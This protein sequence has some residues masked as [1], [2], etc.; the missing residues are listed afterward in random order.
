[1]ELKNKI[2][3]LL[4]L[5]GFSECVYAWGRKGHQIV[6]EIAQQNLTKTTHQRINQILN[7]KTLVEV[8]TWA[9]QMRSM[10]NEFWKYHAYKWHY[11]NFK[12]LPTADI[13]YLHTPKHR[14]DVSNL[15]EAIHHCIFI[16]RSTKATIKQQRF[17]LK[18]LVH[19]VADSHQPLHVG[20]AKDKGG[21]LINV[22]FFN[23]KTNLHRVW[24]TLM[25]NHQKRSYKAFTQHILNTNNISIEQYQHNDPIK[26]VK[27]SHQLTME[28][29]QD[30]TRKI[31]QSYI[32]KYMPKLTKSLHKSGLR[33]AS[34]L[35]SL[36]DK[37]TQ[38]G[39]TNKL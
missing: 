20:N 8:S 28:L 4:V 30:K 1:M 3:I 27:E 6:A 24:D 14:K 15:L 10:Q 5:I 11:I 12:E 39:V 26:W 34:L 19:L 31:D 9:D 17:A 18:F 7:G 38:S 16:L 21:N 33:L 29:Y 2:I 23:K 13:S 35:N 25:I 22:S 36:S 32:K 37:N